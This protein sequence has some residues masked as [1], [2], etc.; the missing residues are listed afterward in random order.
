MNYL[1]PTQIDNYMAYDITEF[2][3]YVITPLVL[4]FLYRYVKGEK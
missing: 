4:Y 3:L 1:Y 2:M